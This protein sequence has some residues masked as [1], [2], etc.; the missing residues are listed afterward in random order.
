MI[1]AVIISISA[2]ARWVGMKRLV[3]AHGLVPRWRWNYL[4]LLLVITIKS[5]RYNNSSIKKM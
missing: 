2:I 1:V 3:L 4:P 5:V